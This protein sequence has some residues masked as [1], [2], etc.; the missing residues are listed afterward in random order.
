MCASAESPEGVSDWRGELLH[1]VQQLF[2]REQ[3]VLLAAFQTELAE[4]GTRDAVM[5]MNQLEHRL[6][7]QVI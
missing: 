6:Q 4:M 5:L 7:E 1:A 3:N 2:V